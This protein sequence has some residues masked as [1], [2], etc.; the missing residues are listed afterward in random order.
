MPA[1]SSTMTEGKVR[2]TPREGLVSLRKP[3]CVFSVPT[4]AAGMWGAPGYEET[5]M[6]AATSLSGS[7]TRS[8]LS[9][10]S[11]QQRPS[12]CCWLLFRLYS[13]VSSLALFIGGEIEKRLSEEYL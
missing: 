7:T 13:F 12:V 5:P 2:G 9:A 3:G 6:N 8:L 1:L 4:V 10:A 11:P